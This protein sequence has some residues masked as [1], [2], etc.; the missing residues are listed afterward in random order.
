VIGDRA[1]I[2]DNFGGVGCVDVLSGKKLW[3]VPSDDSW[4]QQH[5]GDVDGF[6]YG[7]HEHEIVARSPIDGTVNWRFDFAPNTP[8]QSVARGVA[9]RGDTV[10]A[11]TTRWLNANGFQSTGDLV[12]IDAASGRELWRFT[13]QGQTSD[14]Q[15]GPVISDGIAVVSDTYSHTLRA[16]SLETH[17]QLWS[18]AVD[19]SGYVTAETQPAIV[20]DTVFAAST[21]TQI[22][23][24]DLRTGRTLWRLRGNAGSLGSTAICGRLILVVPWGTGPLVAVDRKT[25]RVS[26]PHVMSGEDELF[27]R[28]AVEGNRAFAVGIRGVY[29]FECAE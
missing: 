2:A 22:H 14:L 4:S 23:A 29:A 7:T 8:F 25:L 3:A 15:A 5:A 9:L 27:S 21:D 17:Q 1:C 18:T 28:I 20:H 13:P 10:L 24:Y 16:I 26:Q 11:T 6:Y 12:A 19:D